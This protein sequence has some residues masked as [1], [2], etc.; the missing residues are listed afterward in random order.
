VS[1]AA[2][3]IEHDFLRRTLGVRPSAS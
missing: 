3:A 1:D 2:L